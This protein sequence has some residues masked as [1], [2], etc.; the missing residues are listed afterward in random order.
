MKSTF[1]LTDATIARLVASDPNRL[2]RRVVERALDL[3]R[4][5]DAFATRVAGA[6]VGRL[7]IPPVEKGAA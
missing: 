7:F 4:E 6:H 2:R 3:K 5:R 1:P